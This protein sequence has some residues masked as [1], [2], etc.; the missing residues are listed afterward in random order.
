MCFFVTFFF[1]IFCQFNFNISCVRCIQGPTERCDQT[2]IK[3][4]MDGFENKN[5][6]DIQKKCPESSHVL[7]IT[8]TGGKLML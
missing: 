4:E 1:C 2:F 3:L 5:R 6:P 7:V 8:P